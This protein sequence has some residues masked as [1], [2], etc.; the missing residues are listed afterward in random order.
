MS[1]RRS[2]IWTCADFARH[3]YGED[4]PAARL[5]ARRFL[6]RL[7]AKHGGA[8]LRPSAGTNREYTLLP[9]ALAQLEPDLFT[10]IESLEFRL[11]ELEDVSDR[12]ADQLRGLADGHRALGAQT[13]RNTSDIARLRARAAG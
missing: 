12:Q 4:T 3:A 1:L 9:A 6:R 13:A 7:D 5:R 2:R 8:L 11:E 10:P